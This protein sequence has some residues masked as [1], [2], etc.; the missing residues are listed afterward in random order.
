MRGMDTDAPR[1]GARLVTGEHAL[2]HA[3]PGVDDDVLRSL[4]REDVPFGDLTTAT[5][6]LSAR[7]CEATL[8][9]RRTM[10]VAGIEEA[11]RLFALSGANAAIAR[12]PGYRAEAGDLLLTA[13]GPASAMFAAWKTAQT[14]A[15]ALSGIATYV[16][17]TLDAVRRAGFDIPVACTRKNFPGTRA[18]AARAVIAGGGI[19]HRLGLS[20]T[21][22]VFPQ[23]LGFVAPHARRAALA[24]MKR[25]QPEKR[26]VV[27]AASM[28]E[29]L[30]FGRLGADILQLERFSPDDVRAL[31]AALAAERLTPLLAPT[32]GVNESNAADYA[33]AGADLLV[34]SAPYFA[35][36]ADVEVRI[37]PRR[38]AASDLAASCVPIPA[39]LQDGAGHP[40]AESA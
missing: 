35:P 37:V 7:S 1:D 29:A 9:A 28:A 16:A 8:R 18:F 4:L 40:A 26:L 10:I 27:E 31:R 21:L 15:E 32:G 2:E 19:M 22:L 13:F 11:A 24:D 25:R 6:G 12:A 30:E 39:P 23:H 34:T 5:L 36:P 17:R 14:L 38:E 20:E 3:L 33:R